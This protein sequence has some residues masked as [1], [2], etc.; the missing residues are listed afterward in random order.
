MRYY[1]CA[2]LGD[3]QNVE[4]IHIV[5][6]HG[7]AVCYDRY[8]PVSEEWERKTTNAVLVMDEELLLRLR[9]S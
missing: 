2:N 9:K 3:Y 8:N 1:L 5:E 6:N 4:E 7:K